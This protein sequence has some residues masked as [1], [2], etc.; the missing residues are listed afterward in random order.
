MIYVASSWRNPH[1]EG[2][3]DCLEQWALKYYNWRD[4]EGFHWSNVMG[5]TSEDHWT[6]PVTPQEY[7]TAMRH[8]RAQLGFERDMEHLQAASAVI[9]LL[10]CG[11]SAHLEV[12]WAVG[13]GKPTALYIKDNLQ[14]ELMYGMLDLITTDI[15]QLMSWAACQERNAA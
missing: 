6:T 12:G 11:K 2:V 15:D 14:P 9:L 7:I 10:E 4:E 13:A 8:P 5:R 3:L 1:Y